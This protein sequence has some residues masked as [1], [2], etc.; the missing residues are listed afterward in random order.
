MKYD[1]N[2]RKNYPVFNGVLLYFPDAIMEVAY[3][4]YV[5][6]EQHNPGEEMHWDPTKSIGKGDEIIRHLMDQE[7]FDTDGVRHRAKAAW[8]ALELLQREIMNERKLLEIIEQK[9]RKR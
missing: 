1:R 9:S 8:R 3:C 2:N 4:S 5:A 6:N 7:V